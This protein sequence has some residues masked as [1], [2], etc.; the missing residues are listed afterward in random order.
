MPVCDAEVRWETT[1]NFSIQTLKNI[2]VPVPAVDFKKP[3][4]KKKNKTN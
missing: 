3:E 4:T 2:E 1:K